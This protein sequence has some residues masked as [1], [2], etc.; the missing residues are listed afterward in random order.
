MQAISVWTDT[1]PMPNNFGGFIDLSKGPYY[2]YFRN[3]RRVVCDQAMPTDAA[4]AT[5]AM[6]PAWLYGKVDTVTEVVSEP[7]QPADT[8]GAVQAPAVSPEQVVTNTNDASWVRFAGNAVT[9]GLTSINLGS[10]ANDT[11][12]ATSASMVA[13]PGVSILTVILLLAC[14]FLG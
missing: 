7:Q 14:A 12:K 2:S 5:V 6:G 3:M 10:L 13:T 4:A 9:D 1:R 8:T 11:A